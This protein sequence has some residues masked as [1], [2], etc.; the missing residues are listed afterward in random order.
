MSSG[1]RIGEHQHLLQSLW[2]SYY[3][4]KHGRRLKQSQTF[5]IIV[6]PVL[7]HIL[8][9]Y[10]ISLMI[11]C[12]NQIYFEPLGS[13]KIFQGPKQLRRWARTLSSHGGKAWRL[14]AANKSKKNV[15]S[16]RRKHFLFCSCNFQGLDMP[17][18]QFEDCLYF[19]GYYRGIYL[20]R[21][22]PEHFY[23]HFFFKVKRYLLHF[24]GAKN[25]IIDNS[26][27]CP[28]VAV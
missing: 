28:I 26:H 21:W 14:A 9:R 3:Q 11:T 20:K 17:I 8:A 15:T 10:A 2:A 12:L 25:I 23:V 4:V 13:E 6:L 22:V 1:R 19:W 27:L 16:L 18:S 5:C 7:C 24:F